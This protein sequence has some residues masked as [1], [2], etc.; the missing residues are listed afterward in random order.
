MLAE[1]TFTKADQA[2]FAAVSGDRNP[3]HLD[4]VLARRTPAG[5]P[6]VHGVH[7][8]LWGLDALAR[9]E[10][11]L[12]PMRRLKA[13]FKH[14]A[15]VDERVGVTSTRTESSV[16]LRFIAAGMTI[17]QLVVDFGAAQGS[18][19]PLSGEAIAAPMDPCDLA[20]DAMAERSGRLAFA[21]PPDAI[22]AMFPAASDW[23]GP[24]RVAALAAT[25]LLVG[26]VCPGLHSIYGG[27]TVEARDQSVLED[28]LSFRV[29]ATD[30]RVRS[31]RMTVEGGGLAGL[32]E[33][34]A[35][36]PP[37]AQA[38]AHELAETVEPGEFSGA[39]ALIIGGSRGL[40]EVTAKLL[41]AGGA[42][43]AISYRVGG[44]EA[45]AVAQ[46]IR[47]AGGACKTLAY[48]TS[49]PAEPQ[50]AGLA[51]APTHA[52]YFATPK[53]FRA[54]SGLFARARLDAFLNVYVE[55]FLN[56]AE[57][58]RARRGDV[59]LFYPSSVAVAERPRGML[60]YAM[61]KAAGE[62]LCAE[63]N[64]TWRPLHVTVDRLPRLA[65]DQTASVIGMSLPSPASRLLPAVRQT[66][67]WPRRAESGTAPAAPL[68][69][70][71][72][73]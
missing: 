15:G 39:A 43:V 60:E 35:R 58:L 3:V 12:P 22:A 53:I 29:A 66:Q 57:A 71:S 41:A 13:Q 11:A 28:R 37:A 38:S 32:V 17:A 67:S 64:E 8:L 24:R 14:F 31:V 18:V 54:Q 19:Q 30:P 45:E 59:S 72:A 51:D 49:L 69:T 25:T 10:P 56:L 40:G 50:L 33:S 70:A 16:R 61:A 65:T 4:P 62:T 36:T 5:A 55:G 47:S 6:V 44:V 48:D 63:M 34:Y 20:F 23:L 68:Q 1:R 7:L 21:S 26:M 52:Y 42:S 2:R 46:E 73:G 27:L 9:A